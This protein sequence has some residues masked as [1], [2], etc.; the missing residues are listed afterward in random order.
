MAIT[1]IFNL[2][3]SR[4]G[5]PNKEFLIAKMAIAKCRLDVFDCHNIDIWQSKILFLAIEN[6]NLLKNLHSRL[7]PIRC[8]VAHVRKVLL[9]AGQFVLLGVIQFLPHLMIHLAH[10]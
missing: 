5:L 8:V 6:E 1:T 4:S 3:V 10:N 9:A 7:Q 2:N